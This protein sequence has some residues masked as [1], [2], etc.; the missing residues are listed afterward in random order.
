M[1]RDRFLAGLTTTWLV[2]GLV[3]HLIKSHP[4][5]G[6][7]LSCT[8]LRADSSR[9]DRSRASPALKHAF[10]S[11][12][13][14]SRQTISATRAQPLVEAPR[15]ALGPLGHCG[16]ERGDRG[17]GVPTP[18]RTSA[19]A[20][21][22]RKPAGKG[23]EGGRRDAGTPG[24]SAA[25]RRWTQGTSVARPPPSLAELGFRQPGGRA[26]RSGQQRR[27]LRKPSLSAQ[28]NARITAPCCLLCTDVS[29]CQISLAGP[30][31]FEALCWNSS[32]ICESCVERKCFLG[33]QSS[34]NHQG[35]SKSCAKPPPIIHTDCLQVL[36][37]AP[38]VTDE[39]PGPIRTAAEEWGPIP[40]LLGCS[41]QYLQGSSHIS[42]GRP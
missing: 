2:T 11:T 19:P 21:K 12:S 3:L 23:A 34:G 31:L 15:P 37:A 16:T 9:V 41:W 36:Q 25:G 17:Q 35:E 27:V 4:L 14:L 24:L 18:T 20:Q 5:L 38:L 39:T 6:R 10:T 1:M 42:R 8:L 29:R 13:Y 33:E 32:K 22:L 28:Q 26:R 7:Y 30:M 40:W